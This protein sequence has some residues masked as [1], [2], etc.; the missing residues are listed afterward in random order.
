MNF[1]LKSLGECNMPEEQRDRFM[2]YLELMGERVVIIKWKAPS[3][4]GL[5]IVLANFY[6][7]K[8]NKF[9]KAFKDAEMTYF[10]ECILT[11]DILKEV[12]R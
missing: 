5:M 11:E 9:K 8:M 7:K 12:L 3:S 10:C 4:S 1:L 6:E 2:D